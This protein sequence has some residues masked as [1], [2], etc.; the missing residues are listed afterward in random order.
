F[1]PDFERRRLLFTRGC[2]PQQSNQHVSCVQTWR[3][4]F[5]QLG[6]VTMEMP[7]EYF[8]DVEPLAIEVRRQR[9]ILLP[10]GLE[11][12]RN[13]EW[14]A[15]ELLDQ[16]IACGFARRDVLATRD[17]LD[18]QCRFLRVELL[19]PQSIEQLKVALRFV[20]RR[21]DLTAQTREHKRKAT[22][23]E[24]SQYFSS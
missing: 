12:G 4:L 8:V 2:F 22:A 21:E 23:A 9:G 1:S 17:V 15:A 10:C 18:E 20:D 16:Q 6:K 7:A 19:E 24:H 13:E 14:T 11:K 5:E 3:D